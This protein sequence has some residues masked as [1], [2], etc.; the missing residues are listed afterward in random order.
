M[1]T[2]KALNGE[3]TI[4]PNTCNGGAVKIYMQA[5]GKTSDAFNAVGTA[6]AV[7][8]LTVG[9]VADW[10]QALTTTLNQANKWGY[11]RL[12]MGYR[13]L[14]VVSFSRT[15]YEGRITVHGALT[16][17]LENRVHVSLIFDPRKLVTVRDI[18]AAYV[19]ID[20]GKQ[21]HCV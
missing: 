9:G 5:E 11:T 12:N 7:I 10:V 1:P 8:P 13:G 16:T 2:I 19:K 14:Q 3:L 6:I 17:D 15:P 4:T 18:L 20:K 21:I